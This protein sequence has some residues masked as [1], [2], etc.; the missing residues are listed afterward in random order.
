LA[1]RNRSET[2]AALGA[3]FAL[4]GSRSAQ[5]DASAAAVAA[6]G[7]PDASPATTSV[8][9]AVTNNFSVEPSDIDRVP[10]TSFAMFRAMNEAATKLVASLYQDDDVHHRVQ[11]AHIAAATSAG[12]R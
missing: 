4:L 9:Q 8:R 12:W 6:S 5:D 2:E 3:D 11:D 7:A 10:S 1:V